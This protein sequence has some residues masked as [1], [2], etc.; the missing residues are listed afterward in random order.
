MLGGTGEP[1]DRLDFLNST[2]AWASTP[3][4]LAGHD[5]VLGTADD[6]QGSVTTT[7]VDNI[8]FWVG[9]LAE[10]HTPFGG[11]LGSTFNFVFENQLEKL[12][13]GDRFYYLERTAGLSFG[14][15]LE[16]NSFAKMIMANTDAVHLPGNVF[17]AVGYTLEVDQA[18]Q[19]NEHTGVFLPGL[20]GILGTAD[21]VEDTNADPTGGIT[22]GSTEIT[23]L[24]IRDNPDTI[25]PDTNYLHY[26][27]I[28]T[29]AATVVLGGTEGDDIIIG[30]D[31]D[32]DTIWGDGGND[33]LDGGYGDDFIR[34]G[35]GDDIIAD[36]G[37]SDDIQGGDGN[38]VI[39]AGPG[40]DLIFGGFGQ[41]FIVTGEDNDEAFGGQGDDF[42]LGNKSNEQ[43]IGNEGD[44]WLEKGT[45]DG[46]PGDNFD[47]LGN[48]PIR[49]ND[50]FI[51]DG[52]NDKFI[53]EGGD[54]I[55]VGTTGLTD[56]MFGGS[57]FDWADYKD[58][59]IGV[60][61]DIDGR[62]FDQPPVPG[63]GASALARFDIMEGLSGSKHD[64]YLF[65]D[66]AV[67]L[68][69]GEVGRRTRGQRT[70]QHRARRWPAGLPR[71]GVRD[72]RNRLHDRQH[73]P[74]R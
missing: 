11:L 63:S 21:D 41:D 66:N 51:G 49:G 73:H 36:R 17:Q 65:G 1:A 74:R 69:G 38:D 28:S 47:P 44:D 53:G 39:Q 20:D 48:D 7:G 18:N 22:I 58:T 14:N 5:H 33:R 42:I 24:V 60:T 61:I 10:Q 46:A 35:A 6:V 54:D 13:D 27:G 68:I 30:G 62:F 72:A 31:S 29:N 26:N 45:S 56:R 12:Q 40:T 3:V 52:E 43:D 55:M 64:D 71:H 23:P 16:F 37:G 70:H 59:A 19:F 4:T 57:G 67:D 50:I 9:G 8:D 2:G 34:G 25:G 15:E 32:D